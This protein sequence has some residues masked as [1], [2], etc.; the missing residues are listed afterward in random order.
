MLSK[1][2]SR[3]LAIAASALSVSAQVPAQELSPKE[4]VTLINAFEVPADQVETTIEGWRSA[5]AFL[6][7][8]PGYIETQLHRSIMP[9]ARFQLVN[10]AR[11]ESA[12][13]Y[14]AAIQKYRESGAGGALKGTVFHAA[15][16]VPIE[17]ED[18]S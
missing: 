1:R 2:T 9:K 17:Q 7:T 6:E 10:V 4:P 11:W 14:A 16:Y 8:Q 3:T 15:L 18:G 13:D 12:D 5:R